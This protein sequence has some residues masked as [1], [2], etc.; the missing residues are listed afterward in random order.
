MEIVIKQGKTDVDIEVRALNEQT[1]LPDDSLTAASA[2][3]ELW[4]RRTGELKQVF[5]AVDLDSLS[6]PHTPGGIILISDGYYRVDVPDAAF[7]TGSDAV[8][9]GGSADGVVFIGYL[10]Q[11]SP[12]SITLAETPA[13]IGPTEYATCSMLLPEAPMTTHEGCVIRTKRRHIPVPK[14]LCG[15]AVWIMR[16]PSGAAADLSNCLPYASVSESGSISES[17]AEN[18]V[19][20]RFQGCDRGE[21]LGESY[22]EVVAPEVGFIQF[23]LPTTVCQNSGIYQF[24][25]AVIN[26]S[27]NPLFIDGGLISVEHGL[28]GD[29]SNMMGP[30]TIQEIRMHLRDRDQE[31]DLL[32]AVEFDDAEILE[33]IRWPVFNFNEA[34]PN[35]GVRYCCNNFPFRYYWVQ[36]I[37]GKLL[38]TA[39]HH[40]V[41]NKMLASSGGLNV[42]DKNKDI[43]YAR[44]ARLYLDEW[45]EFVNL[46]KIELNA[47]LAW[48]D[49]GSRYGGYTGYSW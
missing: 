4:Y 26:S 30:P 36:A 1:A 24:Q 23:P 31:N 44:I 14:G 38:M 13:D 16:K 42:D 35:L 2:G 3:L 28:W 21:L 18:E 15:E 43:D 17:E 9:V 8:Y 25:A 49:C 27:G 46:K 39:V 32:Q 5:E 12:A 37:V 40:Y 11:L 19:R 29:T 6:S 34:P 20:V 33:A 22:A 45:Q 47:S 41:R 48:G 7:A 10:I